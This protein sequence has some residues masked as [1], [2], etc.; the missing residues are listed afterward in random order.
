M[1]THDWK[2]YWKIFWVLQ[3]QRI[4]VVRKGLVGTWNKRI[5]GHFQPPPSCFKKKKG[6]LWSCID[7]EGRNKKEKKRS[8]SNACWLGVHV[9]QW[10][11]DS[12]KNSVSSC[13]LGVIFCRLICFLGTNYYTHN[14]WPLWLLQHISAFNCIYIH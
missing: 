11:S 2:I 12:E 7:H 1:R 8:L 4:V 6:S 9:A 10:A 3:R 5:Y 14:M 13:W